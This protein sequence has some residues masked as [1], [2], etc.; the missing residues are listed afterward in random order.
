LAYSTHTIPLGLWIIK[1]Y[2]DSLPKELDESAQ[3]MGNSPLRVLRK[4]ILP[5]SGPAVAIAFILNFL[6]AWNG[7]LLAFVMLQ[8]SSKYTLPIKL[9]T[10]IGSIESSSPEWGMFAAASILVIIPLLVVFVFLKNYL[11]RGINNS[12]DIGET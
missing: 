4:I 6:A 10:F 8:S 5:L 1:G 7:F 2:I 3:I 11:I 9:Y 12:V